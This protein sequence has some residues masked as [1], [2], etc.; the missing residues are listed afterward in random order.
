MENRDI[1]LTGQD[2]K[3]GT[4]SHRHAVLKDEK[5][6]SEYNRLGDISEKQ[7]EFRIFNS[8]LSEYGVLGF[9]FGYSLASPDS[10]VVW[11]AQFGDFFNGAQTMIDQFIMSAESKWGRMSG[12]VMLLPHG[13]EG[14]GPEHSSARLERF[15][16]SSAEFNVT[17]ANVTKPANFFHLMRRQLHRDFR[18][19]LI[20]MSPKSLLRFSECVSSIEDFMPG[21]QFQEVYDDPIVGES[22]ELI[23]N[24]KIVLW[25]TGKIYYD[26]LEKQ[27]REE[28][29]DVAIVRLEQLYPF[30]KT[31]CDEINRK[32]GKK[33]TFKW[34]Q[35]E[36]SNMGAWQYIL[37]FYRKY[38]LQLVSRKSSA[39]PATGYMKAHLEE[40]KNIVERAFTL[41]TND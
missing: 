16:Q 2:V 17:V 6:Y 26:L 23:D 27:R 28:R 39:S 14:Q 38:D 20:V 31:Q 24:V 4:F 40:Q 12:L 7:G 18:K 35:E 8:L 1:R 22:Q 36:P 13:Y 29:H 41:D 11:E 37:A 5:N 34:V 9:E 32:Y 3:R 21:T 19:P 10:L 25:C 33:A 15:L 30:P